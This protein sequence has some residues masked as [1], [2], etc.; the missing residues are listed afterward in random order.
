[1][2]SR[3]IL[4][5]WP[6]VPPSKAVSAPV[7]TV[8][9]SISGT[10]SVGST[11]TASAGTITGFPTPTLSYQ[12]LRNGS[13]IPGATS[14]TYQQVSA[15]LGTRVDVDVT[16]SNGSG[17]TRATATGSIVAAASATADL[18]IIASQSNLQ[19]E[20]TN[21]VYNGG[22]PINP[23]GYASPDPLIQIWNRSTH[24]FETYQPFVN[25]EGVTGSVTWGPEYAFAKAWLADNPGKTCYILKRSQG[26]TGLAADATQTDWAKASN[27]LY[28]DVTT[29]VTEAKAALVA[30]GKT[31]TVQY[32][33]T[34]VGEQ[35]A[36][37][38]TKAAAYAT[39]LTNWVAS[40]R[41]DWGYTRH[42]LSLLHIEQLQSGFPNW[43]TVRAGMKSVADADQNVEIVVTDGAT[44]VDQTLH[45][46]PASVDKM[47][48]DFYWT[49][50]KGW[51]KFP[52]TGL[53]AGADVANNRYFYPFVDGDSS[54]IKSGT[55]EN[56]LTCVAAG[57]TQR[58]YLSSLGYSRQDLAANTVR[59]TWAAGRRQV[60]IDPQATNRVLNSRNLTNASWTATS[61]TVAQDQIG[62]DNATNSASSITAT[63]A[64]ATVL[65]A[66]TDATSRARVGTAYVKRLTGTGTVEMTMD[67]GTTWTAITLTTAWQRFTIPVQTLANPSFGF[68]LQTNG[69]AIATDFPQLEDSSFPTSHFSTG[70]SASTR[71]AEDVR[72]RSAAATQGSALTMVIKGRS[73]LNTTAQL[74]TAD[75][76]PLL[77]R[78]ASAT[79]VQSTA[80]DSTTLS[81]TAGSGSFTTDY[82]VGISGDASG[83]KVCFNGGT[84]SSDAKPIN[85]RSVNNVRLGMIQGGNAT[86]AAYGF[87]DA[88]FVGTSVL[89]DAQLQALCAPYAAV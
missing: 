74:A 57:T 70:G 8:Q 51:T 2:V 47:G 52:F 69:D 53:V 56:V 48:R 88:F 11:L 87:Y 78:A 81:A 40:T 19:S 66:I 13:A 34:R 9:P 76:Q 59:S 55:I 27:E 64:N 82:A 23:N 28:A 77:R 71:A 1:M 22:T 29:I 65:Q 24:S 58:A 89:S 61:A 49:Y 60:V 6:L 79:T 30:A 83:R 39:N 73:A 75:S 46:N 31:P 25:S 20:G 26:N 37:D 21:P 43:A 50:S 85:V 4:N 15:D 38:S 41:T 62:L 10:F 35:D 36:K 16:A 18:F 3:A 67:G 42:C 80:D 72:F 5:G 12:W 7:F 14:S 63:A 45:L 17:S 33:M 84:V 68:R 32:C 86:T 44:F 54:T